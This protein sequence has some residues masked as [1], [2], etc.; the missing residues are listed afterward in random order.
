VPPAASPASSPAPPCNRLLLCIACPQSKS[1]L[2]SASS[3]LLRL[4]VVLHQGERARP[5]QRA[6]VAHPP[7]GQQGQHQGRVE[8]GLR[9]GVSGSRGCWSSALEAQVYVHLG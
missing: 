4:P 1:V 3:Q 6:G 5:L 8:H 9:R 7:G 2:P